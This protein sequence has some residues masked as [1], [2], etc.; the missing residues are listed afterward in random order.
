VHIEDSD[1][2]AVSQLWRELAYF[3]SGQFEAALGHCLRGLSELLGAS[4]ALWVGGLR[5]HG[6]PAEEELRGW[7][8]RAVKYLYFSEEREGR[9][10]ALLR[11][12]Y[13]NDVDPMTKANVALAGKTRALLR[14]ELVGDDEWGKSWLYNE[15]LHPLGVEDRLMGTHC[16]DP[17]HESYFALDRGPDDP[18]FA[19][20]ERDMLLLFLHGTTAFHRQLMRSHGLLEGTAALSPRE[21]EV[22]RLLLTDKSERAIAEELGLAGSTVHQYV[23]SILQAFGVRRRVGLMANWLGN[24]PA[25]L[26]A[27]YDLAE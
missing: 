24:S 27:P 20:R 18:P 25:C 14:R 15:V 12:L 10:A 7:R 17:D 13:A 21:R 19:E 9:V 11:G 22:L 8:P 26:V 6:H 4:N 2:E 1:F 5:E 16:I 23:V 3:P